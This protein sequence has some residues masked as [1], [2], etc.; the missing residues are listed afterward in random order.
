MAGEEGF[1]ERLNL[2]LVER[3]VHGFGDEFLKFSAGDKCCRRCAEVKVVN[4]VR[5]IHEP[6]SRD[7]NPFPI[8]ASR[9]DMVFGNLVQNLAELVSGRAEKLASVSG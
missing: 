8:G 6:K 3:K 5:L 7:R 9:M 1:E 4:R 2:L